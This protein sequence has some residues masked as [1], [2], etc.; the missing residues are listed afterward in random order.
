MKIAL[1]VGAPEPEQLN[2]F[3][4]SYAETEF[5]SD[6]GQAVEA[7]S[8]IAAYDSGRLVGIGSRV[9][10]PDQHAALKVILAPGYER[11]GI[12]DHMAKLLLPKN[13][14]LHTAG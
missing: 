1:Q 8:V 10:A 12:R 11:R 14:R 7:G 6:I 13:E 4:Q 2:A 9:T 5:A 3:M